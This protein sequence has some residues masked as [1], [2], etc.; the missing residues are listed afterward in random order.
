MGWIVEDLSSAASRLLSAAQAGEADLAASEA[1]DWLAR[2]LPPTLARASMEYALAVAHL[3]RNDLPAAEGAA[4]VCVVTA[5]AVSSAEWQANGLAVRAY[6]RILSAHIDQAIADLVEAEVALLRC[7]DVPLWGSAHTGVGNCFAELRMYEL[8][9]PHMERALEIRV[10]PGRDEVGSFVGLVNLAETQLRWAEELERLGLTDPARSAEHADHIA[11]ATRWVEQMLARDRW[12]ESTWEPVIRRLDAETHSYRDPAGS[13]AR[14]REVR[15][16]FPAESG[17]DHYLLA[18]A[19][20]A[21]ALR[22]TGNA[23]EALAV[24]REGVAAVVPELEWSLA[25]AVQHQQHM[26]EVELGFPGAGSASTYL[27][28][29]LMSNW[30]QRVRAV[31]GA[32]G[33]LQQARLRQE[34]TESSRMA[35]E[36]PLTGL[37]NR[38]AYDEAVEASCGVA[39]GVILIDLDRF[40]QVNDT[41]GHAVG[42]ALLVRVADLLRASA[43]AGDLVAR[44]GGDELVVLVQGDSAIVSG[45]GRRIAAV[46]A[47]IP[48]EDVAVGLTASAS[49]GW[50]SFVEGDTSRSLLQRADSQMY[51]AKRSTD[52]PAGSTAR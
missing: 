32:S 2:D 11:A 12:R 41:F 9:L 1:D 46:L 17:R 50:S 15:D 25:M 13:I 48:C 16:S 45:V 5:L 20:L 44:F 23:G 24:A 40:K 28:L 26:A 47:E 35:R 10:P 7:R 8:A 6:V 51:R 52:R 33:L 22:A 18:T 39:Q 38:R 19:A 4:T 43:R 49:V 34:F 14:L 30:A 21:R 36:D 29:V 31:E 42:D 37:A 3:T 27:R